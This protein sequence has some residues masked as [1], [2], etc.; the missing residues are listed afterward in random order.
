MSRASADLVNAVE[1]AGRAATVDCTLEL[2][3]MPRLV[4]AG[5][6]PGTSANARL[7]FSL[8]EGRPLVEA[9]VEGIVVMTC[10]RCMAPCRCEI[11]ESAP[12]LIAASEPGEAAGGYETLIDDPERMSLAGVVQEQLL[13]GLPLVPRHLDSGQCRRNDELPTV[14]TSSPAAEDTQ[15]PFANLRDLLN[16]AER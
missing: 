11:S 1:L 4:E 13:L 8:F 15:R 3:E 7:I 2:T 6:L 5:A 14:R 9:Q 16:D 10:Q 12:L